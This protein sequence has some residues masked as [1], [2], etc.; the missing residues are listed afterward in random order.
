MYACMIHSGA[1][2]CEGC[3]QWQEAER[4]RRRED[5]WKKRAEGGGEEKMMRNTS[6]G[7]ERDLLRSEMSAIMG[8]LLFS[9]SSFCFDLHPCT[10]LQ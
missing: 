3:A 5:M 8:R 9:S 2:G 1:S 6:W 10:L 4:T 7:V